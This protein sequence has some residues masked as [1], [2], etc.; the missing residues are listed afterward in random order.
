MLE[1]AGQ[2]SLWNSFWNSSQSRNFEYPLFFSSQWNIHS[3]HLAAFVMFYTTDPTPS[4]S[5]LE[6]LQRRIVDHQTLPVVRS[7][8][9]P[10]QFLS[11]PES[12]GTLPYVKSTLPYPLALHLS[13]DSIQHMYTHPRS[14]IM[15]MHGAHTIC[16]VF[17]VTHLSHLFHMLLLLFHISFIN[18]PHA[19]CPSLP[20]MFH[21]FSI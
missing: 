2:K 19:C 14:R 13:M 15:V 18:L 21:L 11:Q 9:L 4:L 12:S 5:P 7:L 10:G 16:S 6:T 1:C 8:F 3:A 20:V 17:L